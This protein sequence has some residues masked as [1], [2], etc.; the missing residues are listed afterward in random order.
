MRVLYLTNS[1]QI[2][3]GNRALE[4]LWEGLGDRGV[5]PLAVVPERGPMAD[6]CREKSIPREIL[7][8]QQPSWREPIQTW[9]GLRA[10][11]DLLDRMEP[12]LVHANDFV[13]ARSI[14]PA[15]WRRRLPLI[16]HVQFHRSPEFLRWV[17][18]GLPKPRLFI[19]NSEATRDLVGPAL[20][21]HCPGSR[22]EVVHNSVSLDKFHPPAGGAGGR[23]ADGPPRVGIVANLIPV[24]GHVDFLDMAALLTGRGVEAEYW[25]VGDDIHGVGHRSEL[26]RRAADL[27]V[28]ERVRFLGHR[29]DVPDVLRQL[30]AVV[31]ASHVEPFGICTAEA[32]ATGL[33]VVGTRV[34]GIREVIVDGETGFFVS[35]AAPAELAARVGELLAD[36]KLRRRMG[37]AGRRRVEERFSHEVYAARILALYRELGASA[38]AAEPAA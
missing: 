27:G 22:Q 29:S 34:G 1:A 7:A 26:E 2:G 33:P 23:A 25:I 8:Y 28:A 12:R 3:G 19:H 24:K 30:D 4:T 38:A 36:P 21:R 35:P 13:N 15:A 37:R 5:E 6:L 10:W 9:R 31:V 14:A 18:R 32:M 11:L 16:C 20:D 17:F